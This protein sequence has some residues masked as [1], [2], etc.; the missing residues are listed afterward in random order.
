LTTPMGGGHGTRAEACTPRLR[1]RCPCRRRPQV[2][3]NTPTTSCANVKV[4]LSVNAHL[5]IASPRV[6]ANPHFERRCH[7]YVK[8]RDDIARTPCVLLCVFVC[9][10]GDEEGPPTANGAARL[11]PQQSLYNFAR[12]RDGL[13][14]IAIRSITSLYRLELRGL[15]KFYSRLRLSTKA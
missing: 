8:G 9:V 4:L 6:H 2:L 14:Y 11:V 10:Y 12:V 7:L 1:S 5:E 13:R 15:A 3:Q